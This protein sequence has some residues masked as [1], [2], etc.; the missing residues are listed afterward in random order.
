MKRVI[1][2]ADINDI[3]KSGKKEIEISKNDIIT[4]LAA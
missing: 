3:F 4:P 2:E 1:C